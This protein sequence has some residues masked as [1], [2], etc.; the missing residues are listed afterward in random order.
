MQRI[1]YALFA[2]MILFGAG[3]TPSAWAQI[4]NLNHPDTTTGNFFGISV[5]T[6]GRRVLVGASAENV[7]GANSG[8]AY[9]Y[10]QNPESGAWQEA[11]RLTPSDCAEGDFFGRTLSLSGDRALVAAAEYF[12]ATANSNA[13]YIFERDSTGAW[14]ETAKLVGDPKAEEG[15]FATSVALD[16]GRALITTSGDPTGSRYEGAAYIYEHDS[17]TG[18][19]NRTARLSVGDGARHGNFGGVGVLDGDRAAVA[20]STYFKNQPGSIYLFERQPGTGAWRQVERIDGIDDLFITMDLDGDQ[21][22][23][24]ESRGGRKKAGMA[25]LFQ[26]NADGRWKEAEVF[27]PRFP[28]EFGAFGTQVSLHGDRALIV[29]FDEQLGFDFNIDRVVYMFHR[30]AETRQWRQERIIDVGEVAFGASVA[31]VGTMA[32]IGQAS[33]NTVGAAY[34][35][36]L[37]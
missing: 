24:G 9:I 20:S 31:H 34:I 10:E 26:R 23:V 12:F 36:R 11:A 4:T 6:D 8:A 15:A 33:E 28:Y 29:G 30:D 13:A 7:C 14:V 32:V 27:R 25:T 37:P 3:I 16:G 18:A 17:T 21:L 22:L 19:W 35:V 5:A 2:C 1:R